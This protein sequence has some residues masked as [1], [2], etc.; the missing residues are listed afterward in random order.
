MIDNQITALTREYAEE[1]RNGILG[2]FP[3]PLPD[4]ME[5]LI[6]ND[7]EYYGRFLRWLTRRYCLVEKEAVLRAYE[8]NNPEYKKTLASKMQAYDVQKLLKSLI[9]RP[10]MGTDPEQVELVIKRKK[11]G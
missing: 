8:D 9:P 7:Q 11:N 2:L 5:V 10:H 3:Q 1:T 6:K 4:S